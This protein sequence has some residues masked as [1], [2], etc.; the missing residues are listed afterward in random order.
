MTVTDLILK[1][2]LPFEQYFSRP[3]WKKVQPLI[4]GTLL[5]IGPRRISTV[6]HA[7]GLAQDKGFGRFHRVLNQPEFPK[8]VTIPFHT[9][10]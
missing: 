7:V 4:L 1:V 5:C 10:S 6:L 9:M 3:V 2:M 8:N